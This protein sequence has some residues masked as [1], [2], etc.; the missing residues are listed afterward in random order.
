M[1][2]KRVDLFRLFGFEIRIDLSW[3]LLVVLVAWSL[4]TGLFPFRY[5]GLLMQIYWIMG[6]VG[7]IGLFLS[8]VF[9]EMAHSLVARRFGVPIKGI[10]LFLFGGVAEMK[11]EPPSA[12]AEFVMALAGPLSSIILAAV[13][14]GL[15]QIAKNAG[16]P[17]PVYG[18][19]RYLAWINAILAAFNLIPAF[20]LDG[21]R[22]L[23]AALWGWKKNLRWATRV[24]AGI[25]SGFGLFLIF[26]GILQFFGGNF[27]GGMWWFF[28]GMF[29][30]NAAQT[31]YTQLLVRKV[32]EGEPVERFMK[33]DPV[34]VPPSTTVEELVEDFIYRYQF[35]LFPVVEEGGQL[36]GC[37]TMKQVKDIP[38]QEWQT[39]TVGEI[40]VACSPQNSID[41][42]A[43]ALEALALMNR[44]GSSRLMVTEGNRLVGVISLKDMMKFF[45]LKVELEP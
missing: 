12:K 1:F 18:V 45:E 35:K 13:F 21:G 26:M 3:V 5:E 11:G 38:R 33:K 34:T 6:T 31:S 7:A 22:M 29:L 40:A 17:E 27:I 25:G 41:A 10:T 42:K 15:S 24:A 20:P 37:V 16:W 43:D 9:H 44:T 4:S 28:I 36:R 32:L 19:I 30:R 39:K 2:G 8:I 23:R 14:Y